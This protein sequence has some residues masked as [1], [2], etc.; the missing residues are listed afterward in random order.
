MARKLNAKQKKI[1]DSRQ[2]YCCDELPSNVY[3]ALCKLNCYENM[4]CDIDRYLSDKALARVH[5]EPF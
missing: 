2:E 1:L 4:D 5:S 3:D